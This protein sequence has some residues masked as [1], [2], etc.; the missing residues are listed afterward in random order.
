MLYTIYLWFKNE[1]TRLLVD[2]QNM[3]GQ[4]FPPRAKG[5]P[6]LNKN[7]IN[8]SVTAGNW[9]W[10][11]S[12]GERWWN[13]CHFRRNGPNSQFHDDSQDKDC[14]AVFRNPWSNTHS[15]WSILGFLNLPVSFFGGNIK[16]KCCTQHILVTFHTYFTIFVGTKHGKTAKHWGFSPLFLPSFIWFS[17]TAMSLRNKQLMSQ[18]LHHE[19]ICSRPVV[20]NLSKGVT[21]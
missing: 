15:L 5:Q 3:N 10:K 20:L 14:V 8:F 21:L 13:S 2:K 17:S 16:G 1:N 9:G 19:C 4:L 6:L 7:R 18:G 11:K 12:S